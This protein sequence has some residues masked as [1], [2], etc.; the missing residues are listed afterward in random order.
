M[1]RPAPVAELIAAVFQGTPAAQ[2]LREGAIWQVW[3]NAVGAQ[4]ASRARPTAIRN[5]ILTVVVASSPWLQQ[6]NFLKSELRN[7]L[8]AALGEEL[9]KD[10][11]LKAGSFKA[12]PAEPQTVIERKQRPLSTEEKDLI[13][14]TT[15]ELND[16]QLRDALAGLFSR[17]LSSNDEQT[18]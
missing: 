6:L 17:H 3:Q 14:R 13:A 12:E 15:G 4:I 16:Q 9:I 10:I 8:N 18:D 2:R 1:V 11:Y 5:G 7:K